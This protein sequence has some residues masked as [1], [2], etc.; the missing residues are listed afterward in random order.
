MT[1]TL[2][3]GRLSHKLLAMAQQAGAECI[4]VACPLCQ[5]NLDLRQGDATKAF[6]ALPATPVF[7]VTQL[8]GLALGLSTKDVGIDALAVSAEALLD[9]HA[10]AGGTE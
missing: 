3:V 4:A 8:L 1:N 7:Y 6:G 5:V 10:V 2:V 9:E